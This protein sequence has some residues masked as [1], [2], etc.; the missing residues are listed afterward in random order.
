MRED[1]RN[2]NVD[3]DNEEEDEEVNN[4]DRGDCNDRVDCVKPPN[5][6]GMDDKEGTN[7]GS[8]CRES[9]KRCPAE[10]GIAKLAERNK[11]EMIVAS[12]NLRDDDN[13]IVDQ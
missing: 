13:F 12:P 3:D 11:K 4:D 5:G 10:T 7:P 6:H 1:G 9:K 2:D 8:A